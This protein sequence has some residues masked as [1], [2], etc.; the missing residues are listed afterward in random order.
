M[1]ELFRKSGVLLHIS[2]LN[3][4]EPIGTFGDEAFNFVDFMANSGLTFWQILP[5][6]PTGFGNCPYQSTSAFAGNFMFISIPKLCK[7]YNIPTTFNESD[8]EKF[9]EYP[10]IK[11]KFLEQIYFQVKD[12]IQ[13]HSIDDF[14]NKH[15]FWLNDYILFETIKKMQKDLPINEWPLSL[16][17]RDEKT[18]Q[19]I[20]EK[21]NDWIQFLSFIQYE[22]FEQWKELKDYAQSKHI[23]FIGD[24]PIYVNYNSCDVWA[25]PELFSVDKSLYPLKVAGV[26]PDYFSE[27][28]QLW[29]NPVYNWSKNKETG[30]YWWEMRMEFNLSLFDVVRIDHFRAFSEYWEVNAEEKTAIKGEWKTGPRMDFFDKVFSENSKQRIIAEDLGILTDDAYKLRDDCGFPGMRVL[31]FAFD[32]DS[33][34]IHLPHNFSNN[35][36][37]YTGT[38]DNN[39]TKGWLDSLNEEEK[40]NLI[41]YLDCELDDVVWSMIR[42]AWLSTAKIAIVPMQDYLELDTSARMNT[43]GT[44]EDNWKWVMPKLTDL[45]KLEAKIL[46]LNTLFNR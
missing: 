40:E 7:K 45:Q 26:P 24:I 31:Q 32:G 13:V 35:S 18:L 33:K 12:K 1:N 44:I 16:R 41:E 20:K 19:R 28:G 34:N 4:K 22:F 10:L 42:M 21:E 5:L 2:S 15:S 23:Q 36:I 27:E 30:Y 9:D 25:N 11:Q 8:N 17:L 6:G 14:C 3:G 38:H 39:T 29:G 37:V 43:P 46:K